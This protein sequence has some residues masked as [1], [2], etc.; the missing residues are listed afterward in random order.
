MSSV[1]EFCNNSFVTKSALLHHQQSAKYC[2]KIQGFQT[3][4]FVCR[5]CNKSLSDKRVL[6]TH[7]EKCGV[8]EKAK[9]LQ[10]IVF[11]LEKQILLLK[12]KNKYYKNTIRDLKDQNSELQDKIEN[13]AIQSVSHP[14][15]DEDDPRVI[16]VES[17][18]NIG[19]PI[20]VDDPL[21]LEPLQLSDNYNIEY[22]DEDGYINVTNLCK[23][24]GKQFKNWNSIQKTK[25]F[26]KV[27]SSS[28][29]ISANDL[30][31]Y[32]SGSNSERATWVHPQVAINIAQWISPEFDVKVS[33]WVYEIMV[34]GKMDIK[35]SKT[36]RQL[37]KENK[38]HQLRIKVLE[39][40]YLKRHKRT[41]IKANNVIYV[42]ATE[43][44]KKNNIYILGKASNLTTRL[45]V[46]NKSEEGD[47][48]EEHDVV[49]YKECS[50]PEVMSSVEPVIFQKLDQYRQQANRERFVLPEGENI[51]L[52]T[53]VIERC[54]QF[55]EEK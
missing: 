54:I 50:S 1:C 8:S 7:E 15:M 13:I 20:I 17:E 34:T 45:S 24:G 47:S 5:N 55:M 18:D 40:R 52:F 41:D 23:A 10:S 21:P 43:S 11:N 4:K 38:D 26:L 19:E 39:N 36:Y 42:L 33:G 49:F 2:L 32:K 16:E 35:N 31:K 6:D 27:L 9:D 14:Y 37:Q 51:S 28:V 3:T 22:R 46:Y 44:S 30:I 53:G 25:A 12:Q 48:V 29:N